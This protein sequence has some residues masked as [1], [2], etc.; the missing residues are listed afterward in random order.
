MYVL[1]SAGIP[2]VVRIDNQEQFD[3]AQPD[4]ARHY[5]IPTHGGGLVV[6]G[7]LKNVRGSKSRPVTPRAAE[8]PIYEQ[9]IDPIYDTI[10]A[11]LRRKTS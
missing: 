6:I 10:P 7:V 4:V 9:D 5:K 11:F 1:H 2:A 3:A 8:I